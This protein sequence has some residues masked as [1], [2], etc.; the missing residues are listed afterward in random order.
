MIFSGGLLYDL[1]TRKTSIEEVA[2]VKER[3]IGTT[4]VTLIT[5]GFEI[6]NFRL[7]QDYGKERGHLIYLRNFG[8][9]STPEMEERLKELDN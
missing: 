1:K 4:R 2:K 8:M 5:L 6:I 7:W 3:D 9:F